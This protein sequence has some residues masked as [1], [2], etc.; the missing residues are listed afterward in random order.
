MASDT[1]SVAIQR[2]LGYYSSL[3]TFV[4][5]YRNTKQIT[6]KNGFLRNVYNRQSAGKGIKAAFGV[7]EGKVRGTLLV[8]GEE[9]PDDNALL[10]RCVVV[11]V[12]DKKRTVNHFNWFQTHRT[13]LS[14]LTYHVL[15]QKQASLPQFMENLHGGKDFFVKK[16]LDDR[17]AINY[18]IIG[19]GYNA[20]F[21][22]LPRDFQ[23]QLAADSQKVKQEYDKEHAMQVFWEDLLAM[24]SNGKLHT[25]MWDASDPD[26]IFI[27]FPGL[28]SI[29][30]SEYRSVHGTEPF[31]AG[32]IRKYME[33]EPGFVEFDYVK[34]I[35]KHP[36]RCVVF[37]RK[38]APAE[39]LELVDQIVT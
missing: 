14:Y 12:N 28:Y 21:G 31:K 39:L 15:R 32:A 36:R 27:Y 29:W 10:T 20:L 17:M 19:S 1:T 33:E 22:D 38:T 30:A 26:R 24:Q 18:S 35:G 5:E 4:D 8:S 25:E 7:R 3:P 23:D 6:M 11:N 16:G 9:T 13:S 2:Y 37:Y 34:K